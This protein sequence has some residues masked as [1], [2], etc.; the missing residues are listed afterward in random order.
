MIVYY[1]WRQTLY[2]K[3]ENFSLNLKHDD[4]CDKTENP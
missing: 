2:T 3:T 1:I 4:D